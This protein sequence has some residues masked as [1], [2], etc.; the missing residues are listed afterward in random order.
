MPYKPP[1]P[2]TQPTNSALGKPT[3]IIYESP[4]P[5]TSSIQPRWPSRSFSPVIPRRLCS[6]P[7][8]TT[9][10][11][12]RAKTKRP[13]HHLLKHLLQRINKRMEI[14]HLRQIQVPIAVAPDLNPAGKERALTLPRPVVQWRRV[15]GRAL[16]ARGWGWSTRAAGLPALRDPRE[17]VPL[18]STLCMNDTKRGKTPSGKEPGEEGTAQIDPLYER[19]QTGEYLLLDVALEAMSPGQKLGFHELLDG[20]QGWLWLQSRKDIESVFPLEGQ[21]TPRKWIAKLKSPEQAARRDRIRITVPKTQTQPQENETN[22][23]QG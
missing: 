17:K 14:F 10:S 19:Y 3:G 4:F 18:N 11:W 13:L 20:V 7:R 15:G 1:K 8:R 22:R 9:Q 16:L 23:H 2:R 12:S 21:R 6:V 5:N